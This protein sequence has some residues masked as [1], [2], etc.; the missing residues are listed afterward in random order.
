MARLLLLALLAWPGGVFAQSLA[1]TWA[2]QSPNGPV[3]L[4][5]QQQGAA[6]TGSMIGADGATFALQGEI[7]NGRAT[8]SI[9]IGDGAG[10]FAM[11]M[12]GEQLKLIVAEVDPATGQPD[13]DNGWELDF[14]RTG[15]AAP[16]PGAGPPPTASAPPTGPGAPAGSAGPGEIP[17]QSEATP[18]LREWLGHLRG[19]R[20]SYRDSYNSNDSRGFGGFSERWDAY[21]CSDGTF[22]FEQRSRST[23]DTGGVIAG[24]RSG[25]NARGIWRIVEHSGQVV[26]QYQ[27]EGSDPEYG[28]LR[29]EGGSTYLDRNRIFVTQENTYCR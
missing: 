25:N 28:V 21:L 14:T 12:T 29:F 20:L 13:L 27:M 18:V 16:T 1:G 11:G 22:F 26:L 15:A 2:F 10:W 8:G 5:L 24:G 9:R 23:F 7:E 6:L 4:S 19:K 3:R 17:P